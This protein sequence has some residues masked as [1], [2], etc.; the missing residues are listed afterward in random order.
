[1]LISFPDKS[2]R[3]VMQSYDLVSRQLTDQPEADPVYDID[4]VAIRD[5]RT[6]RCSRVNL[7]RREESVSFARSR[8]PGLQKRLA[9]RSQMPSST[10]RTDPGGDVLVLTYSDVSRG[11]IFMLDLQH[12]RLRTF[13]DQQPKVRGLTLSPMKPVTSRRPTAPPLRLPDDACRN[14]SAK[15]RP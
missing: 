7:F 15:P 13:L 8:I 11:S 12:N 6:G 2:G 5:P 9:R 14:T 3:L 10:R 4:P 1:V